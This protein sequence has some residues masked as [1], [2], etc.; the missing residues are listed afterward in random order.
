MTEKRSRRASLLG[1]LQVLRS[2]TRGE[3]HTYQRLGSERDSGP[4]DN[5]KA[6]RVLSFGSFI[7]IKN[8]SSI[9]NSL[10]GKG[11]DS[12]IHEAWDS[13]RQVSMPLPTKSSSFGSEDSNET[14]ASNGKSYRK[15]K[16]SIRRLTA[17]ASPFSSP[18][19]SQTSSRSTSFTGSTLTSSSKHKYSKIPVRTEHPFNGIYSREAFQKEGKRSV[20]SSLSRRYINLRRNVSKDET[21]SISNIGKKETEDG[22]LDIPTPPRLVKI[23]QTVRYVR[24]TEPVRVCRI[25]RPVQA[26]QV[27]Q[28]TQPTQPV[29]PIE[30]AKSAENVQ[31]TAETASVCQKCLEH[32]SKQTEMVEQRSEIALDS[33]SK[34]LR[35]SIPQTSSSSSS[36]AALIQLASPRS[37]IPVPAKVRSPAKPCAPALQGGRKA[38][39][40][41]GINKNAR[42]SAIPVPNNATGLNVKKVRFSEPLPPR[43]Q[44]FTHRQLSDN[45]PA[46]IYKITNR[47]LRS[48][49]DMQPK[50]L[51]MSRGFANLK[52]LQIEEEVISQ[53]ASDDDQEQSVSKPSQQSEQTANVP[54]TRNKDRT[55]RMVLPSDDNHTSRIPGNKQRTLTT[56]TPAGFQVS[57]A[58]P[59]QYW[60]GR[61]MTLTNAFHYEDSFNEPDIATGFGMLSSYSRPL[62]HPDAN[63]ANYRVKRAFMVLE[64]VCV[65]EEASASLREFRDEYI[66]IHGDRWM[67]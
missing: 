41:Q 31:A 47:T 24:P 45:Q 52:A 7:P 4:K 59:R 23:A 55:Q 8:E 28:S 43:Q 25:S 20:L 54:T 17:R 6:G 50:K 56:T 11:R 44:T 29:V 37:S 48:T 14:T 10:R 1:S 30:L 27:T 32:K 67:L 60:L 64:N 35:S 34:K 46:F 63:L 57:E 5:G 9:L 65:T 21:K 51:R 13:H 3:K 61:F 15:I 62:G 12:Q 38:P 18:P 42:G 2:K 58:Q 33:S 22:E 36:K 66:A 49:S 53:L 40:E 19:S 16:I 26:V 39:E